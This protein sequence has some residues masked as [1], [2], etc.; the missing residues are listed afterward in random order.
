[1]T[2]KKTPACYFCELT[3]TKD[4]AKEFYCSGCGEHVCEDCNETSVMG[5][6]EVEEHKEETA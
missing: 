1:M 3:F 2:E 6:H 5:N 4:D